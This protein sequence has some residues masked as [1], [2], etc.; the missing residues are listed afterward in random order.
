MGM[1][2]DGVISADH[3]G[4][5]VAHCRTVEKVKVHLANWDC[6]GGYVLWLA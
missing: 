6:V 5:L 3:G 1:R 4:T 2:S